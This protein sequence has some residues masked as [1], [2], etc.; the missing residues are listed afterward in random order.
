MNATE[1]YIFIINPTNIKFLYT[2]YP[3]Q[4]CELNKMHLKF[5]IPCII[6]I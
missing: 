2:V 3:I 4:Q 6:T 5:V 1:N